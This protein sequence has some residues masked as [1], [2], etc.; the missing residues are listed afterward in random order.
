MNDR[1]INNLG[2]DAIEPLT[3]WQINSGFKNYM[4]YLVDNVNTSISTIVGGE[5][6]PYT[7]FNAT[8]T[9]NM[10]VYTGGLFTPAPVAG[11]YLEYHLP[12]DNTT[13]E[14]TVP[15]LIGTSVQIN[16]FIS[17]IPAASAFTSTYDN[18]V[19]ATITLEAGSSLLSE[20]HI[21]ETPV[22]V[23]TGDVISV[24]RVGNTIE[25]KLNGAL[26]AVTDAITDGSPDYMY[27]LLVQLDTEA[28]VLPSVNLT[29]T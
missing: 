2:A 22:A 9:K 14:F 12:P 11:D 29:I 20:K 7:L 28:L 10:L 18:T 24:K 13:F 26:F 23:S 5:T 8:Y 21:V 15:D 16:T 17:S 6:S 27:I 19:G 4:N 1:L 25:I 3:N